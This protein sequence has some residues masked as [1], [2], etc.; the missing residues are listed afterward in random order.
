MPK[1]TTSDSATSVTIAAA[2]TLRTGLKVY[3]ASTERLY[4][5]WA[6]PATV[7]N[8]FK[9]L[10]AYETYEVPGHL[11]ELTALYG[12][13]AANGS[14]SA[15]VFEDSEEALTDNSTGTASTTIAAGVGV[16]A[17]T[18]PVNLAT[19]ADGDVLTTLT[20]PH[21]FKVLSTVAHNTQEV[22]TAA[23]LTTLNWEIGTTNL[24]GG[25]IALTSANLATLGVEV[26]GSAITAANTG[27]AGAT[28][29]LEASSTT[30]FSE[31]QVVV[32]AWIQNMDTAD[33]FASLAT[34]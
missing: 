17:L 2:N 18:V 31:G 12:I 9:R 26:A 27:A 3:N 33:A 34:R 20:I 21:K 8:S 7:A 19:V 11:L 5:S 24:T 1:T 29:S 16:Y 4:I 13:W 15:Q 32:V 23:K 6:T 25:A 14:G 22:T 30:A 10:E 28:L